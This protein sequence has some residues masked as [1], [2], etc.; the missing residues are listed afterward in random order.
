M[1]NVGKGALAI[2]CLAYI[3]APDIIDLANLAIPGVGFID[4]ATVGVFLI[5]LVRSMLKNA[6]EDTVEIPNQDPS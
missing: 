6:K 1:K 4:D 2:L 5:G 3:V